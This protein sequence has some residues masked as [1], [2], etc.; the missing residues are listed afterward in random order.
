MAAMPVMRS[1]LRRMGPELGSCGR[2]VS[3]HFRKSCHLI[4]SDGVFTQF[5]SLIQYGPST[6]L[7]AFRVVLPQL[8]SK[9][10]EVRHA[11]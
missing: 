8:K 11:V 1:W 10:A 5:G 7:S 6:T 3:R 2:L 9:Y 4:R